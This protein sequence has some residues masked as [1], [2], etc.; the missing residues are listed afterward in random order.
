MAARRC[1][2][3][4]QMPHGPGSAS[5]A[6]TVCTA[7]CARAKAPMPRWTMP[8][9]G[10]S[11]SGGRVAATVDGVRRGAVPGIRGTV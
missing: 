4:P 8:T 10:R 9:G 5:S 3:I 2:A 11:S 6:R 1:G 7:W